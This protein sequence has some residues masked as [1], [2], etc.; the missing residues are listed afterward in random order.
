MLKKM[1]DLVVKE[2]GQGLSEYGLIL[3]GVVVVAVTAV[4][5]LSGSIDGLFKKLRDKLNSAM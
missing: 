4:G 5:F 2:E 1:K 3:A